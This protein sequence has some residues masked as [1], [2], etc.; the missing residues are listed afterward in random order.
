M[1]DRVD[2]WE[3]VDRREMVGRLWRADKLI[4]LTDNTKLTDNINWLN[5]GR[6][7]R[8]QAEIRKRRLILV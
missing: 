8:R 3:M 6:S 4:M 5:G 2:R 7:G 1:D